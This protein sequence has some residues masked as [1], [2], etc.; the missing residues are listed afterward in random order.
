MHPI[1]V[2]GTG[3]C[4]FAMA[5]HLLS[6]G[7]RVHIWNR[8]GSDAFLHIRKA[9]GISSSGTVKGRFM[10]DLMTHDI[11]EAIHGVNLILMTVPA[12]AHA[13]IMETMAPHL[14]DGQTVVL[15]PGRTCGALESHKVLHKYGVRKDITIAETQTVV[16]TCRKDAP[17]SVI[18]LTCK[19]GVL[20]ATLDTTRTHGII[21]L[22]PECI[23]SYFVPAS[24]VL[25]TSLGNVGMILHCT[26][27]LFNVGW[28]ETK[29]TQFK[30][31]YEGITPS[32]G[33]FLEKLDM[34]RIEVANRCG[35]MIPSIIHWMKKAYGV[36]GENLY[37]CIQA[38][39]SYAEIDAPRTLQHRYLYEDV[40]TGLVPMEAIGKALGLPMTLTTSIIDL[41]NLMVG[42]DFRKTGRNDVLL[43]LN[44]TMYPDEVIKIIKG[45]K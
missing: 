43:G 6:A 24:S 13:S 3:N 9:G 5:V 27:V 10:P 4:G 15:N 35:T 37:E 45:R 19:R 18:I 40:P 32:V 28:I 7:H 30:Y 34:E 21:K 42:E 2:I 11:A 41:A 26:P 44:D 14:E 17:D 8:P 1:T 23:R 12:N 25:E 36:E 39:P 31:Y 29:R 20:L 22:L 38:N 16:H 33:T